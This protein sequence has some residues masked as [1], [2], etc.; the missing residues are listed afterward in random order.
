MSLGSGAILELA[1]GCVGL[2]MIVEVCCRF[3]ES[4]LQSERIL[5]V[6]RSL[7]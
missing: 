2:A 3:T 7:T 1:L 5:F 6:R 4:N